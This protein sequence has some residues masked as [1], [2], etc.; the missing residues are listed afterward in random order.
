[1]EL[2]THFY[3]VL[4]LRIGGSIPPLN[5]SLH[6]MAFNEAQRQRDF[7]F[8]TLTTNTHTDTPL[9]SNARERLN[10]ELKGHGRKRS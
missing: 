9:M 4:S 6:G 10:N 5:I 1:M 2:T 7:N 3:L 8:I